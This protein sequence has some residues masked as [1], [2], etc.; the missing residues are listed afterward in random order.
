MLISGFK[1]QGIIFNLSPYP[2]FCK[3]DNLV[4]EIQ[5][6]KKFSNISEDLGI[7]NKRVIV[8]AYVK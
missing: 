4:I 1:F 6:G 8:E 5:K 2:G 3:V 7:I